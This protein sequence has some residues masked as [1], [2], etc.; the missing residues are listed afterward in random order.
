[1]TDYSITNL[2]TGGACIRKYKS[3]LFEQNPEKTFDIT[4]EKFESLEKLIE[5]L[6][7]AG[8]P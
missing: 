5:E 8:E 4:K 7:Q 3:G 6:R 2:I 1:M